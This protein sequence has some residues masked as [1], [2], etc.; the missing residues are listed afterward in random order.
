MS[1]PKKILI[2]TVG[3]LFQAKFHPQSC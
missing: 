3:P 2:F 1:V